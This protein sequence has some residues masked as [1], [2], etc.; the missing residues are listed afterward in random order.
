MELFDQGKQPEFA[1]VPE[2]FGPLGSVTP[3]TL[4]IGLGDKGVMQM[5]N[6]DMI[7]GVT[8][9]G[10]CEDLHGKVGEIGSARRRSL[11]RSTAR[12]KSP[13]YG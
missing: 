7:Q 5:R 10:A 13:D 11:W 9:Q 4:G 12:K 2:W 8:G 1:H 3:V 6:G